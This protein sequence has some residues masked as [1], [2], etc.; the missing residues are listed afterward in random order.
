MTEGCESGVFF[1]YW[2]EYYYTGLISR[3]LKIHKVQLSIRTI[4]K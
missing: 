2:E 1:L 3:N 4:Y